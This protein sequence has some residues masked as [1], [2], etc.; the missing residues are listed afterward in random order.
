MRP[1]EY[2]CDCGACI[3]AESARSQ[4]CSAVRS[5][6]RAGPKLGESNLADRQGADSWDPVPAGSAFTF[7]GTC[8]KGGEY[9]VYRNN[10]SERWGLVSRNSTSSGTNVVVPWPRDILS[11]LASGRG[12]HHRLFAIAEIYASVDGSQI[13]SAVLANNDACPS[14]G[15]AVATERMP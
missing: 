5:N 13:V 15:K 3:Q 2:T 7:G 10:W 4:A 8:S 6:G 14:Y 9:P 12:P 11:L 1:G